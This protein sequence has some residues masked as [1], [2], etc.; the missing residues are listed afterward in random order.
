M[1]LF[2]VNFHKMFYCV[3]Y[4]SITKDYHFNFGKLNIINEL[5]KNK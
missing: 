5:T 4:V 3:A 2:H 1:I